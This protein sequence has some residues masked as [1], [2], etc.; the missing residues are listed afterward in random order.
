MYIYTH[1][2]FTRNA[3]TLENISAKPAVS[4]Y[5]FYHTCIYFVPSNFIISEHL[6]IFFIRE[7]IPR[8]KVTGQVNHS[9]Y[10]GLFTTAVSSSY[11]ANRQGYKIVKYVTSTEPMQL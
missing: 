9:R 2:Y 3:K 4:S 11:G 6:E 5:I 10:M 1:T 8:D 7:I